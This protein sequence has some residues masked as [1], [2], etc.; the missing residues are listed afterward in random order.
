KLSNGLKVI[1]DKRKSE[2]VTVTLQVN[3]GSLNEKPSEL[4]ISHFLEH[5]VFEGTKTRTAR[6]IANSIESLGGEF[7]AATSQERT[8]YYTA[9]PKKYISISLEILSDMIKNSLFKP[10]HIEKERRVVLDEIS[11][12]NDDPKSYQWILLLKTLFKKH[13]CRNPVYGTRETMSKI[14]RK[15]VLDYFNTYYVPNNMV[16]S[17]SGDFSNTVPI[18]KKHFSDMKPKV[19]PKKIK[20]TEPPIK[21]ETVREKKQIE[22]SYL[23]LGYKAPAR[24]HKDSYS[25]DVIQAILGRG[26]SSKLFEEIRIKRGLAY[27][28]GAI[29]ESS[30]DFGFFATYVSTDQGKLEECKRILL[31][32]IKLNNLTNKDVDEAKAYI[33]GNFIIKYEDNKERSNQNAFWN[34]LNKDTKTYLTQIKT[35]TKQDVLRAAKKYLTDNY[36][37][38]Y[39]DQK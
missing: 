13:P 10:E 1:L 36:V 22:H 3:S 24:T 17:I 35:V 39:I 6:E 4:G 31:K 30:L 9:L 38:C 29:N 27:A 2:S 20:V 28:L 19:L 34:M 5:L 25:L 7:N 21:K 16:L 26:Q 11:L 14:N 18:I 32:E 8:Y 33:E 12:I 15:Q 23:T 37:A